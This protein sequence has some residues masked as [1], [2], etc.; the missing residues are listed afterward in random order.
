MTELPKSVSLHYASGSLATSYDLLRAQTVVGAPLNALLR[1]PHM[2]SQ[3][4]EN[5]ALTPGVENRLEH[6]LGRDVRGYWITRGGN[7][8]LVWWVEPSDANPRLYLPLA[9]T[10]ACDIDLVV[11]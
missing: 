6:G 9:T 1:K 11:F 7:G 3:L 2:D 4:I 8:A 10:A 5:V